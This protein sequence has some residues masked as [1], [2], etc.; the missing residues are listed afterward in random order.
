M[1]LEEIAEG[2]MTQK[3]RECFRDDEKLMQDK[4]PVAATGF[5]AGNRTLGHTSYA[6]GVPRKPRHRKFFGMDTKPTT[7]V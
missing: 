2:F 7:N 6:T 5:D 1:K 4:L 3:L